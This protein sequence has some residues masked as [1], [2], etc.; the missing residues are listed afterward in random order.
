MA[1]TA[2]N[3]TAAPNNFFGGYLQPGATDSINEVGIRT[4]RQSYVNAGGNMELPAARSAHPDFIDLFLK[5]ASIVKQKG[6]Y[7]LMEV[8]YEG[9]APGAAPGGG[10]VIKSG[11]QGNP[12][13]EPVTS[14]SR[15]V[16]QEP[17]D[18]HPNFDGTPDSIVG[19]A[20]DNDGTSED[21]G[22]IIRDSDGAFKVI[23]N[24]ADDKALRGASSYLAPGAEYTVRYADRSKPNLQNV[25]RVVE[26][27]PLNGPEIGGVFNWLLTSIDYEQKGEVYEI[28]ERYLLSGVNGWADS[29]YNYTL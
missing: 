26:S 28:T 10:S 12:L 19:K 21:P 11:A 4:L 25:G 22:I 5:S 17:L 15:T 13:F 24:E 7:E 20:C 23:S 14:L 8:V 3:P 2:N 6:D 29:I 1:I 27:L 9:A 16:N 18:S